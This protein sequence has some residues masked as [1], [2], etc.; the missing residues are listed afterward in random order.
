MGVLSRSMRSLKEKF[1]DTEL[2][3]AQRFARRLLTDNKW[4]SLQKITRSYID[5]IQIM[6]DVKV[7]DGS[8]VA[9]DF[10]AD[11]G[12]VLGLVVGSKRDG[13]ARHQYQVSLTLWGA[14]LVAA[15]YIGTITVQKTTDR[16]F[17]KTKYDIDLA[18]GSLAITLFNPKFGDDYNGR[19]NV[20]RRVDRK[21]HSRRCDL[22]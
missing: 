17:P 8:R 15:G 9:A 21:R 14:S 18:G 19:R 5:W 13:E 16:K 4:T 11:F 12:R 10:A 22:R 3:L 1:H 6:L 2:P 7:P 20:V